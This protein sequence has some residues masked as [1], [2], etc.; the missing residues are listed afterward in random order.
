MTMILTCRICNEAN[1]N[2][3][4]MIPENMYGLNESFD[5]FKCKNCSCLQIIEYP[6]NIEK[7]YSQYYSFNLKNVIPKNHFKWFIKKILF[8]SLTLNKGLLKHLLKRIYSNIPENFLKSLSYVSISKNSRILDVGCGAGSHLYLL[9]SLGFHNLLGIDTFIKK[10]IRYKN[11]LIIKKKELHDVSGKWDLIMF[12]HSL[13]HIPNQKLLFKS[14]SNLLDKK[15]ICMIRIP[16][17]SSL[18]W[19][20]YKEN[21]IQIDAPRHYY[22]HS[23]KSMRIISEKN[24]LL[25][26]KIIYDSNEFQFWG[27]EQS[28][29]AIPLLS[30]RSYLYNPRKSI[31]SKK[32]IEKYRKIAKTLNMLG[33]GDQAIFYLKNN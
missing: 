2:K 14:I 8:N 23:I 10:E 31:F 28:L 16:T 3:I 27:S 21:W 6:L 13:E 17:I 5:Y 18:A 12:N 7:Y 4:Y 22:L 20:Y 33:K 30:N 26:K 24:N 29:N 9:K 15:G 32:R 11:G 25:L 1:D 19:D